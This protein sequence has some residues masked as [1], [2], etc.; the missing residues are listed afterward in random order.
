M[1][2]NETDNYR[3]N[4]ERVLGEFLDWA[5]EQEIE[6]FDAL[7]VAS[8]DGAHEI[9]IAVTVGIGASLL[10]RIHFDSGVD[11]RLCL[12]NPTVRCRPSSEA[13]SES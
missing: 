8:F 4:A 1:K 11:G 3:R 2:A 5:D 7:D 12:G 6:T 10:V 9:A 13:P